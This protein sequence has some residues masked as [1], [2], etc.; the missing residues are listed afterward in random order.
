MR[1]S[2]GCVGHNSSNPEL[3][4]IENIKKFV[5]DW[6]AT[7]YNALNTVKEV[8]TEGNKVVIRWSTRG[9]HRGEF[10]GISPTGNRVAVASIGI[11]RLSGGEIVECSDEYD[12]MG[13][14]RQLGVGPLPGQAGD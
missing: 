14:L 2:A 12:T 11:F 3:S 5:S 7:F 1:S 9:I 10:M 4:G 13:L 6:H 8:T